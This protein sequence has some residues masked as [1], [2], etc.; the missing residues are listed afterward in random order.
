MRYP[1]WLARVLPALVA[2][3]PALFAQPAPPAG[4]PVE[5]PRADVHL[6]PGPFLHAQDL[7][8]A[9]VLAHDINRLLAPF[10]SEAGLEPKAPKYPNWESMG[11][12]G[13][14]AGHYLT[15]LAQ[16]WANT[17]DPEFKQRLDAM[18]AGLAECQQA[19]GHGYVGGVPHSREVW[20][21]V[22]Q[23]DFK[24]YNKTWV[25]W[26]NEHKLLAGLRDAWLLAG[27]TQARDVLVRLADWCDALVAPL[28]DAQM[29][30]MLRMEHGGMNEVLADVAAITGD[31]K[32]LRLAQ[33]FSHRALLDPLLAHEDKLT[34]LHANTQIP[35]VIGFAR[36]AEL[37]GDP[38]WAGAAQFFWDTVV[39]HRSLAF[40]GN[41]EREHF[42]PSND[43]STLIESREGPET[44]NTYN[45]LRLTEQLYRGAP[46]ARKARY[47]DYY[48]RAL[49]NHI[50][51]SQH[52]GSGGFVYFTPIRPQH[53]RVYS[54]P[55]VSFWCC[56]GT[57]MENHG[58]YNAFIYAH[59]ANELYVNLFLASELVWRERG[60][61]VRQETNFP[62]EGRTRLVVTT[63]QPQ[64]F[65]LR[66]RHPGWAAADGFTVRV[67]GEVQAA[68]SAPASY[69]ALERE[70]RN[71]DTV[72]VDLGLRTTL[73]Q[74]PDGSP[75][76]AVLHGP[77]V[78][79]A[80]TGTEDLEGLVQEKPTRMGHISQGPYLPLDGAPMLVGD[81]ATLA[82][83]IEPV[84]GKP[85]TFTAR[86]LVQPA[87]FRDL[88][89]VP[90][91][92][93]HDAR[94][95]M[96]W[97]NVSSAEYPQIVAGLESSE[98]VRLELEA[99][100]LDQV[101]PGEQQPEV[102]HRFQADGS[103][104]GINQGRRWRDAAGWF[105]YELA[106][107]GK[108]EPLALLLTYYGDERGRK[109]D[110]LA[111][112]RVIATVDLDGHQ[113]DRFLEEAYPIPG[114]IAAMP[115]PLVI[116][117][118]ARQGSRTASVYSLR[119]VKPSGFH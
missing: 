119:L 14:T 33:R 118:A 109:F 82:A 72:E 113:R 57:G 81:P 50:L 64:R 7:D 87:R 62:D 69:V 52:P 42:N 39:D 45:M 102:D 15:A 74:L 56:V 10:R 41:S 78:L 67:N 116:K 11:L 107:G 25:P 97:R 43:F 13:H 6:L 71:G 76:F 86:S 26:Y 92:R 30:E 93:L 104:T 49:Y 77:I 114:D 84:A 23:G 60:L 83:H 20:A 21:G 108:P 22:A 4:G 61:A 106:K 5:F 68:P 3:S 70:W 27:S 24:R 55:E 115:G 117:F 38:A 95:V 88:E 75:Y 90:F 2:F 19:S 31:A 111:N 73:E 34:G 100:T 35:K 36:V 96:Y 40:G 46:D 89:L 63:A 16:L 53:Y 37:G 110:I 80:R 44:C 32:Y 94:Y 12:E 103:A 17:G 9:Y 105:S 47:A 28:T 101:A 65:T 85:L 98:K 91:F 1:Y 51:S 18:V 66:L 79:A 54:K 112:D 99:R 58:K 48:E 59:T 29:Q 8:R